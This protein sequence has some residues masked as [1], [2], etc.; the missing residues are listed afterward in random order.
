MQ[1][2]TPQETILLEQLNDIL[3]RI[4]AE[5]GNIQGFDGATPTFYGSFDLRGNR[6]C[7]VGLTRDEDDLPSRRELRDRSVYL[8]AN[9]MISAKKKLNAPLGI[10]SRIA[11][12]RDEVPTLEQTILLAQGGAG[13][14]VTLSSAQTITGL[15]TFSAGMALSADTPAQ[16]TSDQNNYAIGSNIVQ[17]LSADAPRVITGFVASSGALKIICNVGSNTISIDHDSSSSDVAN[18]IYM[19][20][21]TALSLTADQSAIFWYDTTTTRWRQI[22]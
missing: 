12:E 19:Q 13:G 18:R 22:N 14:T 5:L 11:K 7:K 4:S 20:A 16:I 2:K 21:G 9:G 1:P 3:A 10:K 6:I 15:K 17:R 8:D